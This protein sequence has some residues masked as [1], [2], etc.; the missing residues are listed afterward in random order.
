MCGRCGDHGP[1]TKGVELLPLAAVPHAPAGRQRL[2]FVVPLLALGAFLMCTTEYIVAGLMP[3]MAG[4]FGVSLSQV[5][6]LVTV[7]AVGMM[8][9]P[10][11]AILTRHLPQRATL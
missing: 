9:A 10:L 3:E 8:G 4:S 11:M 1:S 6:S 7:F 2:P 5:G